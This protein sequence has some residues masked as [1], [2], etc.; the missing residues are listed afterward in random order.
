MPHPLRT[1]VA[2]ARAPIEGAAAQVA[3]ATFDRSAGPDNPPAMGTLYLVRHG[4]AS[5]GS[6]NYDQLS[7]LG[8]RQCRRLGE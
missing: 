1:S 4:Q 6:A 7:A 3:A 5:F 2:P 8:Q